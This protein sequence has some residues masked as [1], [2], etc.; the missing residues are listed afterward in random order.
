PHRRRRRPSWLVPWLLPHPLRRLPNCR[1]QAIPEFRIDKE[2]DFD[3]L[4]NFGDRIA[5]RITRIALRAWRK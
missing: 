3:M 1:R 2:L 5:A 4:S